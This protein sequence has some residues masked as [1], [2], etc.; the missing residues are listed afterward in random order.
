MQPIIRSL[1]FVAYWDWLDRLAYVDM[2]SV[3]PEIVGAGGTMSSR[4]AEMLIVRPDGE[5]RN[6]FSHA[7]VNSAPRDFV[8]RLSEVVVLCEP[9]QEIH[10]ILDNLSAR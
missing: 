1:P 4:A 10:I 8:S 3:A 7:R 2:P 6:F 9:Q 5:K